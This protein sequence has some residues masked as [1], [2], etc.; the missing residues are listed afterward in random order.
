MGRQQGQPEQP[1]PARAA[2]SE[3]ST[4]NQSH[5][6]SPRSSVFASIGAAFSS[7][8]AT[9]GTG[10]AAPAARADAPRLARQGSRLRV[11]SQARM[12]A[13]GPAMPPPAAGHSD[14][15]RTSVLRTL[16]Q[17]D[18]AADGDSLAS[19]EARQQP[20]QAAQPQQQQWHE[21]PVAATDEEP[22]GRRLRRLSSAVRRFVVQQWRPTG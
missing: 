2:S 13:T 12:P 8:V 4:P 11:G 19:F 3:L 15:V 16:M 6:S 10:G 14:Q 7:F 9:F 1:F 20:Q 5:Y 21:N 18:A 17:G 22:S